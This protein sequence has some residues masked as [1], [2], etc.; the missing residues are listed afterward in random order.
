MTGHLE[1]A[2]AWALAGQ[3][4]D[5]L[6]V[7]DQ[8][9]A[10]SKDPEAVRRAEKTWDRVAAVRSPFKAQYRPYRA[11]REAELALAK[12]REAFEKERYEDALLYYRMGRVLDPEL[13]EL[14]RELAA[15]YDKLGDAEQRIRLY[16]EYLLKRPFGEN[17]DLVRMAL[18]KHEGTTGTLTIESPLPCEEIWVNQQRAEKLP[19]ENLPVAPG[20]YVGLC[21][22]VQYSIGIWEE[23]HV[24]AGE[25]ATLLFRWAVLVNKLANPPGRIYVEN[26]RQNRLF[27]LRLSKPEIGIA[28]PPDG[29]ALR[30][31]LEALDGSRTRERYIKFRPGQ[32]EVITW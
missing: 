15:T 27:P 5:A 30:V 7:Y 6:R 17:A 23:V 19:V 14:L 22:S 9:I 21:T 1:L 28:V 29:R 2:K 32:R 12:G 25:P 3:A 18:A 10:E 31:K 8:F 11:T 24:K 26:Y 16:L 4:D 20:R 13:L